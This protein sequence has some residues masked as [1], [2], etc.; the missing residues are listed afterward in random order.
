M[1]QIQS[2]GLY[3]MLS[4]RAEPRRNL[5]GSHPILVEPLKVDNVCF[6][7]LQQAY[8]VAEA[9]EARIYAQQQEQRTAS[10]ELEPR[11]TFADAPR[12]G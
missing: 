3:V 2:C 8:V 7:L 10:I 6:A 11:D 9:L 1:F 4:P 12:F 5:F